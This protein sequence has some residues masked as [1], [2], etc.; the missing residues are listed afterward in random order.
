MTGS[1]SPLPMIIQGGM[2]VGVS[3]WRLAR[4]VS[5]LG[6]LGVVS[7]TALDTVFARRLQEG[8]L[9]GH[10]RHAM[11]H[12]PVPEI[13]QKVLHKYFVDGG[14][15]PDIAYKS[16]PT[17]KVKN[18]E[19]LTDLTVL[20]NFVEVFL[21]KE[22]HS[23]I[24]GI[25]LLEK[26]Q[27]PTLPSLFGA[28]LAGVDYVLMGAGIPRAIPAVLDS[29]SQLEQTELR[30]DVQGAQP[31][32]HFATSFDPVRYC[33]RQ[34][35]PLKRPRFLA[36]VSSSALAMSLAKKCSSPVNGFIVEGSTA[37][38]H[39]APPRG[40]LTL[41]EAGQP[42]Y[43][44][45]DEPDFAQFRDLGLP[46]WLAGSYGV[47][48]K[49]N[50]A[51]AAGATG[52]QVGTAFA[53]CNESD[54]QRS[55]KDAVLDQVLSAEA[56]VFTDPMASPTRFPFKVLR[57]HG[58]MGEY[59]VYECRD[60]VCDLGYLR[61][62]YRRPDGSVGYRCPAE[63]EQDY[64]DKGGDAAE[65]LGRMCVCNGLLATIGHPQR[66]KSHAIEAALVTCG[67]AVNTLARYVKPG[68]LTYSARDVIAH[69]LSAR[70]TSNAFH[71]EDDRPA[72]ASLL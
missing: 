38:G 5:T 60:R 22:G 39:N 10:L 15:R 17:F 29:L 31:G 69:L 32:D 66:R 42:I 63:P 24:V 25:N 56:N 18:P 21:A 12:F 52:V 14:K 47:P 33:A 30:L 57:L 23:G 7:G 36:I 20:A 44:P 6:Q 4:A 28:M 11:S 45:R 61:E 55:I 70:K 13:A 27:L 40:P 51:L 54:I 72:S 2:G 41:D 8:D 53:F 49:L 35:S 62:M 67:D 48:E 71:L 46:F 65:S 3:G 59:R 34:T 68:H 1:D 43:G 58:T 26:I 37:G 16:R 64:I 9:G 50:E 19:A